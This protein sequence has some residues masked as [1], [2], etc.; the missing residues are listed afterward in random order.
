MKKFKLLILTDEDLFTALSV[1]QK[2]LTMFQIG[3]SKLIA[4]DTPT[5]EIEVTHSWAKVGFIV[6]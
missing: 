5:I 2:F 4:F 6:L 3:L 1:L